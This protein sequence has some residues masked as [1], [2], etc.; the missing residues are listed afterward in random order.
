MDRVYY[1]KNHLDATG[2]KWLTSQLFEWCSE[3]IVPQIDNEELRNIPLD[4]FNDFMGLCAGIC[5]L[6]RT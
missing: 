6:S 4:E 5:L 1:W 3:D 2:R